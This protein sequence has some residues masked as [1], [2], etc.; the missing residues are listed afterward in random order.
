MLDVRISPLRQAQDRLM[1]P[2]FSISP[3]SRRNFIIRQ[4]IR[5]SVNIPNKSGYCFKKTTIYFAHYVRSVAAIRRKMV[6]GYQV[7]RKSGCRL[8]GQQDIR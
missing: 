1:C 2:V 8:S 5:K 3:V 6:N 7:I 4:H